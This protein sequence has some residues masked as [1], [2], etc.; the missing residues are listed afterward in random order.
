MRP[1]I[2]PESDD[3]P[4]E[5]C[6]TTEYFGDAQPNY[7][8]YAMECMMNEEYDETTDEPQVVDANTTQLLEEYDVELTPGPNGESA[9]LDEMDVERGEN[10]ENEETVRPV[11]LLGLKP[12]TYAPYRAVLLPA[13]TSAVLAVSAGDSGLGYC[14]GL[15]GEEPVACLHGLGTPEN[16][17]C[18]QLLLTLQ[19][20]NIIQPLAAYMCNNS[21]I[22]LSTLCHAC[23]IYYTPRLKIKEI[24]K[25][26]PF[27]FSQ[28][29]DALCFLHERNIVHNKI[30]TE[31]VYI[32]EMTRDANVVLGSL[33]F[34]RVGDPMNPTAD[35][36]Q[37]D[38]TAPEL[39]R[40]G[41]KPTPAS[42]VCAVGLLMKWLTKRKGKY[43]LTQHFHNTVD[44]CVKNNPADRPMAY[45]A[46]AT[47]GCYH[48]RLPDNHTVC[49][50]HSVD[51]YIKTYRAEG[52]EKNL[53]HQRH[54]A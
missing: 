34:H 13:K 27:F 40:E 19:H 1:V 29:L 31:S 25:R 16:I 4:D 9:D 35:P 54:G 21:T 22:V 52:L 20:P 17:E 38:F 24:T 26:F 10:S 28:L 33:R 7:D 6:V 44:L 36:L 2:G 48:R 43:P 39:C 49:A 46:F 3:E 45:E 51:F 37:K 11:K 8:T 5:Q 53:R 47:V 23:P 12:P 18:A 41:Q 42:D 32:S 30:N 15:I 50:V 14:Y